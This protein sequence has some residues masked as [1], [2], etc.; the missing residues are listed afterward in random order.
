M[1]RPRGDIQDRIIEAARGRFLAQGV[2]GASLREIARDAGT[3]IGM[4][5]YYFPAKDDLF[6][7][8]VEGVYSGVVS[9]MAVILGAEGSARDRLRGLFVRLGKASDLELEVIRLVVREGLSSSTRLRRIVARFMRGHVP[10]LAATVSE[11]IRT[12]E[13]DA[14]IP[15]PLILIATMGLGALPQI[16]R[17]AA[18]SIPVFASLPDTDELADLSLRMLFRAVGA[19]PRRSAR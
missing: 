10:L 5:A 13:F 18:R 15:V 7:A 16:A 6:L 9:D 4:V 14:T 12:G 1:A 11:G 2:D 19:A 3:N 17:R 8:V